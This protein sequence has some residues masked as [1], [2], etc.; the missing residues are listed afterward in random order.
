MSEIGHDEQIDT[1]D[2]DIETVVSIDSVTETCE[3]CNNK[4]VSMHELFAEPK[5][6][7]DN[8]QNVKLPSDMGIDTINGN[9]HILDE[10]R[11][12]VGK[13]N[14]DVNDKVI[15]KTKGNEVSKLCDMEQETIKCR[16]GRIIEIWREE[17]NSAEYDVAAKRMACL[18]RLLQIQGEV[19]KAL[20]VHQDS[21]MLV[22]LNESIEMLQIQVIQT[23]DIESVENSLLEVE[24]ANV[25]FEILLYTLGYKE[26]NA[27][28]ILIEKE[29]ILLILVILLQ[30]RKMLLLMKTRL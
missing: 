9:I 29:D 12:N 1:D 2:Y 30:T 28:K 10:E 17:K 5:K 20:G 6:P 18:H 24:K 11:S 23:N 15:G 7:D 25:R 13:S 27:D 16:I 26:L 4:C 21:T 3:N 22:E 14:I 8:N 19:T